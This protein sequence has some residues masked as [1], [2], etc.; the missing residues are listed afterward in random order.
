MT[1]KNKYIY[2]YLHILV[3]DI[4]NN[5]KNRFI[6]LNIQIRLLNPITLLRVIS[7]IFISKFKIN[8]TLE[9]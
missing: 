5:E 6:N 2:K 9:G 4:S 1:I 7:N 3:S 8:D